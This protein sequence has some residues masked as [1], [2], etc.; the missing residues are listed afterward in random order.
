[1]FLLPTYRIELSIRSLQ[2]VVLE[3]LAHSAEPFVL[4][5][6]D[7]LNRHRVVLDGPNLALEIA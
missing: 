2:P 1:M 6:R 5:G 3:V 4:L 7:I